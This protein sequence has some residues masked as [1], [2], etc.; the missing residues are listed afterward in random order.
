[1]RLRDEC[2]YLIENGLIFLMKLPYSN[3]PRIRVSIRTGH[4]DPPFY[5]AICSYYYI[6]IGS[7]CYW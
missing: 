7:F 2:L 1:M 6:S 3:M 4:S 5:Q